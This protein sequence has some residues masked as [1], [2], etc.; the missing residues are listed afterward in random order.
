MP[1]ATPFSHTS[2]LSINII[3]RRC[4]AGA[5]KAGPS[6]IPF[7]GTR[8]RVVVQTSY[9]RIYPARGLRTHPSVTHTHT[10]TYASHVILTVTLL[11]VAERRSRHPFS[12]RFA[13]NRQGYLFIVVVV[14]LGTD[15]RSLTTRRRLRNMCVH[16]L[17]SRPIPPSASMP[18]VFLTPIPERCASSPETELKHPKFVL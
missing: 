3:V 1:P 8:L 2:P 14:V 12:R 18:T 4:E 15:T 10:L 7:K 11:P 9:E 13:R 16:Q 17:Y 5:Q 6:L